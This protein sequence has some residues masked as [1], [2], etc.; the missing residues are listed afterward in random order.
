MT[1]NYMDMCSHGSLVAMVEFN[2]LDSKHSV[3]IYDI[4]SGKA[5]NV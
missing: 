2:D 3:V 4:A 5:I 1:P